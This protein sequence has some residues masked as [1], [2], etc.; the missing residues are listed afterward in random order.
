[1][2]N[3]GIE[4]ILIHDA[5]FNMRRIFYEESKRIAEEEKEDQDGEEVLDK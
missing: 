1:M 2:S 3:T 4:Q 5:D